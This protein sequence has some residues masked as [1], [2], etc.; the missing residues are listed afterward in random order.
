MVGG[1]HRVVMSYR[2]RSSRISAGTKRSKSY[3]NTHASMSHWP[4]SLPHTDLA[5][6][7]SAMVRWRPPSDTTLCQCLAVGMWASG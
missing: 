7:V 1:Q 3:V 4:Y 2:S 6:P 5:Q